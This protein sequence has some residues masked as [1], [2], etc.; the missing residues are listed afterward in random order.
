LRDASGDIS[1]ATVSIMVSAVN[2]AV[3]GYADRYSVNEDTLLA[4]AAPQGVLAN[5]VDI[6][7]DSLS[8]S[9]VSGTLHGTLDLRA[10]GSF[11]YAP[12][13]DF[14]GEDRFIY[15]VGDGAGNAM[16][17]SVVLE[18]IAGND[19]PIALDTTITLDEDSSHTLSLADIGF[20]DMDGDTLI[21]VEIA[22]LPGAGVLMLDGEP[23]VSGQQ[24]SVSDIQRGLLQFTPE[25]DAFGELYAQAG[26]R[27]FDGQ[28]WSEQT[29]SV[30]FSVNSIDDIPRV[31]VPEKITAIMNNEIRFD[32]DLSQRLLIED[33][34]EA[35]QL[36]TVV[37]SVSSGTLS[38]SLVQGL[39]SSEGN[40]T[41]RMSISG[42]AAAINEAFE[43]LVFMPEP[44]F[45]GEV[46][47]TL[48][49]GDHN[50]VD[51]QLTLFI[52][53]PAAAQTND[54]SKEDNQPPVKP[55][56][57]GVEPAT[58]APLAH[59]GHGFGGEHLLLE[60][61]P[62]LQ[63]DLSNALKV[64]W[65]HN[66]RSNAYKGFDYVLKSAEISALSDIRLNLNW[67]AEQQALFESQLH[68]KE[69]SS[70]TS[71]DLLSLRILDFASD[72][73]TEEEAQEEIVIKTITYGATG[74]T[75]GAILWMLRSGSFLTSL[76]L[77]SPAWRNVDPLPVLERGYD[78]DDD[79][80]DERDEL[81]PN[82]TQQSLYGDELRLDSQQPHRH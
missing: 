45:A 53:A 32:G 59:S 2:D 20:A 52:A 58:E 64:F 50:E 41:S 49:A 57:S 72:F 62:Q 66:H 74:F 30:T 31:V 18:V 70:P 65:E 11:T 55:V 68:A 16:Q 9:L 26:V 29:A 15:L 73:Q 3:T 12:E 69:P 47:M 22:M 51:V 37:I 82:Q 42:T 1:T 54:E 76:L 19:A 56:E 35:D 61:K 46:K 8:A 71:I 39:D 60:E 80:E 33:L 34:D 44:G 5:D 10:D 13:A 27:V 24:I 81:I 79:G 48:V 7:G 25:Q 67:S 75:L 63:H 6:D 14:S 77:A 40:F 4:V 23:V 21:A 36:Q 17:V 28:L 38:L 78:S 43:S